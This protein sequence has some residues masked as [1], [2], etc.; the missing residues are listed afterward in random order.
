MLDTISKLRDAARLIASVAD[1]LATRQEAVKKDE[2]PEIDFT[3]LRAL[4]ASK[5][6]KGFI[7]EVRELL[8]KHNAAK[9]SDIPKEEYETLMREAEAIGNA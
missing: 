3:D 6:E 4:L 1:E 5:A 8:G 2:E 9:L 7:N